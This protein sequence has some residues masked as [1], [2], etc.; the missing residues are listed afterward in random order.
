MR[1]LPQSIARDSGRSA[2]DVLAENR[3]TPLRS[4]PRSSLGDRFPSTRRAPVVRNVG[5]GGPWVSDRSADAFAIVRAAI[6]RSHKPGVRIV[7]FS[8]LRNHV[9][10]VVEADSRRALGRGMQGLIW[11]TEGTIFAERYHDRE[12]ATTKQA[13]P[14]CSTSSAAT[15]STAPRPAAPCPRASDLCPNRSH[16][17]KQLVRA[18]LPGFRA[19][20]GEP[21]SRSAHRHAAAATSAHAMRSLPQ[22]IARHADR[23]AIDVLAQKRP[24]PL[25]SRGDRRSAIEF[26][27]HAAHRWYATSVEVDH[28]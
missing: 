24:T 16:V 5:R 18:T 27:R 21:R 25:R 23:S 1:S 20:R 13:A 2:I 11:G 19:R 28:G 26:D 3:S 10:L 8:V 15:A 6:G 7:H 17:T 22:S 12:V 9:H 4:R 14:C